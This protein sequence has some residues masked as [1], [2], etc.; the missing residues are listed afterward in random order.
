MLQLSPMSTREYF[1]YMMTSRKGGAFY[2]GVTNNI[3]GRVWEH[4]NGVGSKHVA[5]YKVFM[6]VYYEPMDDI[7]AAIDWEKRLKRWRRAWKNKLVEERNPDWEDLA[8][9]WY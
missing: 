4:K 9:D 1:V 7:L 6:L 5:K 3:E 8:E 2:V